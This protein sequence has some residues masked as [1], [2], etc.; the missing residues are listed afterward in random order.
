MMSDIW[1]RQAKCNNVRY[2]EKDDSIKINPHL[3]EKNRKS[4]DM[5]SFAE[6]NLHL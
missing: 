4:V 2:K 3:A 6:S 1:R 5:Y